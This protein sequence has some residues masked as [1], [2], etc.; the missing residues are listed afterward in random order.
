MITTINYFS[1][2]LDWC[3]Q[4][5]TDFEKAIRTLCVDFESAH[6]GT[7]NRSRIISLFMVEWVLDSAT[8]RSR[9]SFSNLTLQRLPRNST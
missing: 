4:S 7:V 6:S 5:F 1:N 3:P 8:N 2:L 9:A